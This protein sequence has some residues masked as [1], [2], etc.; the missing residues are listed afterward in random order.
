MP[1][2]LQI[3]SLKIHKGAGFLKAPKTFLN[4]GTKHEKNYIEDLN[5]KNK[6]IKG[7]A[8]S[9]KVHGEKYTY[10]NVSSD[11]VSIFKKVIY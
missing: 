7:M 3:S 6:N 2:K 11:L 1:K 10:F 9:S 4:K 5:S 8:E